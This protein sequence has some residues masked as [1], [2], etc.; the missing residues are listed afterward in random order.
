MRF[1][2]CRVDIPRA[3]ATGIPELI[4]ALSAYTYLGLTRL[5]SI[6]AY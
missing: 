5:C 2:D 1:E 6:R 4:T 3:E